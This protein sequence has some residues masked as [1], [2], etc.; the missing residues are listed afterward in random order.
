MKKNLLII[1]AGI[2]GVVAFEIATEM[3][4]FDK[5]DF[6]DDE[7]KTTPNGIEV[8]GTTKDIEELSQ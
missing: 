5:I 4:C 6:I 3:G 7:R 1:G 2:Y 8:I